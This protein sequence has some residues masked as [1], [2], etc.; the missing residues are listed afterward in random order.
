MIYPGG[1]TGITSTWNETSGTLKLSGTTLTANYQ[2]AL[3]SVQ[4]LTSDNPNINT[5]TISFTLNDGTVNSNTLSRDVRVEQRPTAE[6][7]G[8]GD[9]CVYDSTQISLTLTGAPNWTVVIRRSNL[10]VSSSYNDTT[11]SNITSSPYTFNTSIEGDYALV[12]VT[13][14]IYTT[15]Q[16]T[17]VSGLA[18]VTYITTPWAELSGSRM[19]CPYDSAVLQVNFTTGEAPW[20]ITYTLNGSTP[21][22]IQNILQSPYNLRVFGE[23]AY[24]LTDVSDNNGAGCVSGSGEVTFRP[25]PVA[26]ISGGGSVCENTEATLTVTFAD[27]GS[28]SPWNIWYKQDDIL[29]DSIK[30]IT[31][32]P[33]NFTKIL[34]YKPEPYVFTLS[35]VRDKYCKGTVSGNAGVTVLRAEKQKGAGAPAD[36]TTPYLTISSRYFSSFLTMLIRRRNNQNVYKYKTILFI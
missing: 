15:P 23:G 18:T 7:S 27:N 30:G 19:V 34:P 35:E 20:N 33:R 1:V 3:R 36:R 4:Y 10:A 22:T 14:G 29:T 25:V 26:V 11:I 24:R 13:D 21:K 17:T 12:S 32:N 28:T 2:T 16:T 6:I 31:L 5:R 9:I 8:G